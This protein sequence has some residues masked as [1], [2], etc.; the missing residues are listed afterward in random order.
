[1]KLDYALLLNLHVMGF[2]LGSISWV[3]YQAPS[4]NFSMLK[5]RLIFYPHSF[6]QA[7]VTSAAGCGLVIVA[8]WILAVVTWW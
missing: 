8:K 2:R 4:D 5:H 6:F 1:M 3:A 7:L